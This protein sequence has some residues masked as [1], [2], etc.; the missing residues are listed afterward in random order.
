MP[1]LVR[2]GPPTT[3]TEAT[4]AAEYESVHCTAEDVDELKE[5][6][7]ETE[8]PCTAVPDARLKVLC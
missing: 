1:A 8:P 3:L 6:F 2:T 5:R 7:N 4:S